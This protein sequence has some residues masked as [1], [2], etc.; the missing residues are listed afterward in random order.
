MR[1]VLVLLVLGLAPAAAFAD[2]CASLV[3]DAEAADGQDA[4][5]YAKRAV[6]ACKVANVKTARPFMV[7]A[8]QAN[9]AGKLDEVIKWSK[10]GLEQ[11]PGLPLAYMNICAA[12]TQQK[13]YDE[14]VRSCQDGLREPNA[15]SAK[16][17]FNIGLA[18][19]K[20][21][22]DAE[23]YPDALAAEP[24]FAT[25][26]QL[27]P[28]ILQNDFYLGVLE[29]TV[30]GNPQA[31]LAHYEPACKGGDQASCQALARVKSASRPVAS[32]A[33]PASAEEVKLW[34]ALEAAYRKKGLDAATAQQTVGNMQAS[35]AQVP[36]E[37]RIQS[38]RS[39]LEALK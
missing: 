7:L 35:L 17:N 11:E 18:L 21:A 38:L 5:A 37:Q 8:V 34:E 23:K 13:R 19:F 2:D 1:I 4:I 36:A 22:V 6:A 30:K 9:R 39:M 10:Q 26:K 24:Y 12:Q 31:A 25:S 20:K 3:D 27:D 16:L 14:A 29:E 33:S 15:W 32:V 28:K